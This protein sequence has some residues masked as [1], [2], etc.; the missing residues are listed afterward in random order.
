MR[1]AKVEQKMLDV[2]NKYVSFESPLWTIY[3]DRLIAYKQLSGVPAGTVDPAIQNYVWELDVENIPDAYHQSL[4]RVLAELHQVPIKDLSSAGFTVHTADEARQSMKQRMDRVK[5]T[6]GVSDEL[7]EKW[8]A[9]LENE[10]MWPKNNWFKPWR[11]SSR[12]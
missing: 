10:A 2:I 1:S 6:L 3:T 5:G 11:C 7:W 12:P 9:W 8:Q 4:G